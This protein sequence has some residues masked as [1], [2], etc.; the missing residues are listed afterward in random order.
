[1]DTTAA[2]PLVGALLD[3]RYRVGPRVARGGMATV[4]EATDIRL[5]RQVAVKVL[6]AGYAED[7]D[8]V[9][10]FQREA[11]SAARLAHPN[12]VSVFDQ[13]N[14]NGTLF[15][16][17]EY[18]PGY[19][20]RDLMREQGPLAGSRAL[21]LLEPVLSALSAAHA[22]GFVHRDVKPENVLLTDDGR[23]KVADFGLARA[24]ETSNQ[25]TA[26]SGVLIGTVS[27]LA[28]EMVVDGSAD[29]RSDVY[30]SGVLLYEMLT[31]R[32][33][34]QGDSP[35]QVAYKHVHEDVPPPS[36][37]VAGIPPYLDALVAR[38][39]SRQREARFADANVMLRQVRRVRHALDHGVVDD[40]ELTADLA[41]MA[42]IVLSVPDEIPAEAAAEVGL[43]EDD[44][45]REHTLQVTPQQQPAEQQYAESPPTH[46][47]PRRSRR[48]LAAFLVV[49]LL[50]A[51]AA[52]G[53]WY[54]GVG[55][56]T[57]APDLRNM[58]L[59]QA[60]QE[61][62]GTDLELASSRGFSENVPVGRIISTDP[63]AGGRLLKSGTIEALVSKGKER[64][65]MPEVEGLTE[66]AALDALG[67]NHLDG[68]VTEKYSDSVDE[69]IVIRASAEPG[70]RL[71]R[72]A[73]VELFVSK[74]RQPIEVKDYTG[75][76][77]KDA[78][79]EL[80][81]AK[82]KPVAKDEFSETVAKGVVISQNPK[83]GTLFKGDEVTLVV[84]AGPPLV[85][86][87]AVF[88]KP[89]AEATKALTDA[90]FQ[91][92]VQHAPGYVGFNLVASQEPGVGSKAPKGSKVTIYLY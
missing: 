21:A 37:A 57:D 40:P 80:K 19:T 52:A 46:E 61:L 67:N 7:P 38:A 16:A 42:P 85:D 22:A 75:A 90:G 51:A 84:S 32:K 77:F 14:D 55:R 63:E 36:L 23:V 39:T 6:H 24:L 4:Y 5:D 10:R 30:A 27:Y 50:A 28:P 86:V 9:T 78:A 79:K 66:R 31:G 54:Y 49:L 87:P 83:D 72:D 26:T 71:K 47:R 92:D 12:A 44:D 13:G 1:M 70:H 33:P 59:A 74:G 2:D 56:F 88:G 20:L 58:T 60:E 65:D 11:R 73:K 64:Y 45:G 48:G 15:L 43:L 53:G 41:P 89:E 34:H 29:T 3:G 82:L 25:T 68:T 18:V 76:V 17:M 91:V 8:F 62:A 35:I 69:G 81:A